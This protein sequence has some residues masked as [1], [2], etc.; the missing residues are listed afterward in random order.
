MLQKIAFV[1]ERLGNIE[2]SDYLID[3]NARE[4]EKRRKHREAFEQKDLN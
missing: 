2:S 3:K 4:E 1:E